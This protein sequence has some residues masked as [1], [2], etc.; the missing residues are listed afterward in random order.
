VGKEYSRAKTPTA[1]NKH[2]LNQITIDRETDHTR[3]LFVKNKS[4]FNF[5][6]FI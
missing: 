4:T 1:P 3:Y 2:V 5:K 6:V